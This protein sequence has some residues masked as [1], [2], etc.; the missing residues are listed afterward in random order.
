MGLQGGK[1]ILISV[2]MAGTPRKKYVLMRNEGNV[3]SSRHNIVLVHMIWIYGKATASAS[4]YFA[5]LT[6]ERGGNHEWRD[7]Q[8]KTNWAWEQSIMAESRVLAHHYANNQQILDVL[9][10]YINFLYHTCFH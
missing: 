10:Y 3:Y 1:E 5:E 6:Q 2:I 4:S 9:K 7:G 8:T